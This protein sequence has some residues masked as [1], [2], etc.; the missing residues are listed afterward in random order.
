[1]NRITSSLLAI[2]LGAT[3]AGVA[4]SSASAHADHTVP[5]GPVGRPAPTRLIVMLL[6]TA[7]GENRSVRAPAAR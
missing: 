2:G 7:F 1:M 4:A 5:V 6:T 3:V